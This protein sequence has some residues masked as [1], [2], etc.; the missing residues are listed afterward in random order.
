MMKLK[1]LTMIGLCC[2][3]MSG[4]A[5]FIVPEIGSIAQEDSRVPY[6]VNENV[7][8]VLDTNDLQLE[9]T[10]AESDRGARFTGELIFDR[11]LTDSFPVIQTFFL[12]M[13]WLGADGSVLQTVDISPF[14]RY[15]GNAPHRLKINKE[16]DTVAGSRFVSFNYYGVF[17]GE[18]PDV[19]ENWS[20]LLFPFTAP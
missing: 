3:L 13:S 5:R 11:S 6:E 10:L 9:Y 16:I 18:R 17:R 19:S 2:L 14:Y 15:L 8:G 12:K 20:I 1:I 7:N 4:C